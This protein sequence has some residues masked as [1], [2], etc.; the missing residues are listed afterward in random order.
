MIR[1]GRR[2]RRKGRRLWSSLRRVRRNEISLQSND[3][4]LGTGGILTAYRAPA[5]RS[6]AVGTFEWGKIPV[7]ACGLD[8]YTQLSSQS[9]DDAVSESSTEFT[10]VLLLSRTGIATLGRIWIIGM[11]QWFPTN[12]SLVT[13]LY[14]PARHI[15]KAAVILI[16]PDW[17]S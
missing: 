6:F 14:Y 4:F 12:H 7:L 3:W 2:R 15:N 13:L 9:S 11:C 5:W 1:G 16:A 17:L 10:E 8:V